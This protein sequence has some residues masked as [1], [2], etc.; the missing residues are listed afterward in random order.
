VV[1]ALIAAL[2]GVGIL[3]YAFVHGLS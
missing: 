2:A 3:G 1:I